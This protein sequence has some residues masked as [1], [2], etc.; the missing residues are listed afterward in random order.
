MIAVLVPA[1]VVFSF[2]CAIVSV[3]LSK[4]AS[5]GILFH[6]TGYVEKHP[7]MEQ[8]WRKVRIGYAVLLALLAWV[9][10]R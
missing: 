7:P 8:E 2:A 4:P 5:K 9:S 3:W 1:F 6:D 10:M